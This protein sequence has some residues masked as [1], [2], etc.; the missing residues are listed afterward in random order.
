MSNQT[1]IYG[2]THAVLLQ[3]AADELLLLDEYD[4][5]VD[6]SGATAHGPQGFGGDA[7]IILLTPFVY[8][9]FEKFVEKIAARA[10]DDGWDLVRR[11][12]V[13]S[14][15]ALY[16]GV[17]DLVK[18]EI[19]ASGLA[20]GDADRVAQRIVAVIHDKRASLPVGA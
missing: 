17:V 2:L 19:L 11:W 10:A 14:D 5:R 8:K 1:L 9:F 13:R 16:S 18:A 12:L 7:V 6:I 4:P 20:P 3:E 15:G